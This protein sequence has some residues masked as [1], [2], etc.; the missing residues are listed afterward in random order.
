[1]PR[2]EAVGVRVANEWAIMPIYID[3][4]A[5]GGYGFPVVRDCVDEDGNE[6]TMRFLKRT[7]NGRLLYYISKENDDE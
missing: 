7:A 5:E 3:E 4:I 1:M 2:H 6:Y